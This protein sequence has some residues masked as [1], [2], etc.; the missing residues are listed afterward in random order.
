MNDTTQSVDPQRI[1][2]SA[3]EAELLTTKAAAALLSIGERTL[4]RYSNAGRAPAPIRVGSAVR[5]RRRDLFAWIDAGCPD[6]R[7]GGR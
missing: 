2:S 5:Y 1:Q 3:T 4:W 6:L 7:G